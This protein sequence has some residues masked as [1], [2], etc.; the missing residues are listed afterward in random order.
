[1]WLLNELWNGNAIFLRLWQYDSSKFTL[2]SNYRN[3]I[4]QILTRQKRFVKFE[5]SKRDS[6]KQFSSNS[7][8][9]NAFRENNFRQTQFVK[10][11]FVKKLFVKFDNSNSIR[12][13]I[14]QIWIFK[15]RFVKIIFIKFHSS[16]CDSS[17][18]FSSNSIRQN[19]DLYNYFQ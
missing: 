8:R 14:R 10:T 16:K 13:R 7:I 18:N 2:S 11:R 12:L 4:R 3:T 19:V 6:W 1:M 9:Q 5:L 17:K 15:T